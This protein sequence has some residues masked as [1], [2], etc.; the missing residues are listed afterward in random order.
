MA[1]Q[2]G[3]TAER[4]PILPEPVPSREAWDQAGEVSPTHGPHRHDLRHISMLVPAGAGG[5]PEQIT[6]VLENLQ[7]SSKKSFAQGSSIICL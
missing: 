5:G 4:R 3:T 2:Y 6:M 1:V 7:R